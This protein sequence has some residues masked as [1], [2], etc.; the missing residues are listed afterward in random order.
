VGAGTEG[1]YVTWGDISVRLL[2]SLEE[3]VFFVAQM[4]IKVVQK[5]LYEVC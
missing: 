2:E 4:V 3:R 5:V 1:G